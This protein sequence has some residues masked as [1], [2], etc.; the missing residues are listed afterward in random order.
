MVW[1]SAEVLEA[2]QRNTSDPT[3]L[4]WVILGGI[5]VGS[6]L[7]AYCLLTIHRNPYF[8]RG[9]KLGWLF[10]ALAFPVFGPISWMVRA[11][12]EKKY[13]ESRSS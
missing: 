13:Q 11:H 4:S 6:V 8:S 1:R 10:V 9:Q 5:C 7:A 12:H 2:S 3:V